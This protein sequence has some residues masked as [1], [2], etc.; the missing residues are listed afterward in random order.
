MAYIFTGVLSFLGSY[1]F[2]CASGCGYEKAGWWAIGWTASSLT[3]HRFVSWLVR[4][5]NELLYGKDL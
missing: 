5:C 3:V 4:V 2:A 1:G